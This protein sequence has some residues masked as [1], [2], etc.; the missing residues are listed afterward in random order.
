MASFFSSNYR[1]YKKD[2]EYIAGWLAATAEKVGYQRSSCLAPPQSTPQPAKRLK[3]KARK[4]AQKAAAASANTPADTYRINVGEFVPMAEAIAKKV[5][6]VEVPGALSKLFDRAIQAREKAATW[7]KQSHSDTV[8]DESNQTHAHFVEI[9][10][11][12]ADILQPLVKESV[13]RAQRKEPSQKSDV[14]TL[15]EMKNTFSSLAVDPENAA[16]EAEPEDELEEEPTP[17]R[18]DSMESLPPVNPVEIQQDESEIESE[19]FFAIQSFITNIHELRDIVQ[20]VWFSYKDGKVDLV[21]ASVIANTAI[22]LVRHAESEFDL[23]LVRPKKYPQKNYPV[24]VLPALLL[25]SQHPDIIDPSDFMDFLFPS[26]LMM[27]GSHACSQVYWCM[28]PVYAGLKYYLEAIRIS[29]KPKTDIPIVAKSAFNPVGGVH[30]DTYRTLELARMFRHTTSRHGETIAMDEV[31]RGMAHMFKHRQIPIWTTFGIQILLDIQDILTKDHLHD[32]FDEL[33]VR[34]DREVAM[35]EALERSWIQ[36]FPTEGHAADIRK[37]MATDLTY[38]KAVADDPCETLKPN[39]IRCGLLMYDAY[40]QLNT[41]GYQLERAL[42]QICM[43]TH[44]YV[45]TK[46]LHPESPVWPDMEYLIHQQDE[47]RLFFGGAPQTLGESLRKVYLMVGRTASDA[48]REPRGKKTSKTLKE[49]RKLR[50]GRWLQ[51]PSILAPIFLER[52]FGWATT[53]AAVDDK[54]RQ[55]NNTLRSE[56]ELVRLA[57]KF[58]R[59]RDMVWWTLASQRWRPYIE[60]HSANDNGPTA[61]LRDLIY[62]LEGDAMD[63]Y[64]SWQALQDQCAKVWHHLERSLFTDASWDSK[65]SQDPRMGIFILEGA[66]ADEEHWGCIAKDDKA[67]A[68]PLRKAHDAIQKVIFEVQQE[69]Q[70]ALGIFDRDPRTSADITTRGGD[71]CLARLAKENKDFTLSIGSGTHYDPLDLYKNWPPEKFLFSHVAQCILN[72]GRDIKEAEEK[73]EAEGKRVYDPE[74]GSHFGIG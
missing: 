13:P 43:M 14:D 25:I 23:T 20:E 55:L 6:K 17:R 66:A 32:P 68:S 10:R 4:E 45:A 49:M 15:R 27:P 29:K 33:N 2:T 51:E 53:D 60:E 3:G 12:A 70:T 30:K 28:W 35:K 7:F 58:N 67:F 31:S 36:P 44:L 56:T 40:L 73:K 42:G 9:L 11:N 62:W 61:L 26:G 57:K 54:V 50:D 39:P 22:D 72:F 34:V 46:L 48:A 65:W 5:P 47:A 16:E 8:L 74:D 1:Q 63:L 69:P 19:F 41:S 64:F 37:D 52:S 18:D 71:V 38:T 59:E 21:N 24:W